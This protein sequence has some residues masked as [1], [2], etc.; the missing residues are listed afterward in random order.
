MS[1]GSFE[2]LSNVF[3]GVSKVSIVYSMDP[4]SIICAS[5]LA[6]FASFKE[7]DFELA[8]FYIAEK[9][10]DGS[11]L[12]LLVGVR[13]QRVVGGLRVK[14]LWD[15]VESKKFLAIKL[16]KELREIWVVSPEQIAM[17]IAA[18]MASYPG[19]SYSDAILSALRSELSELVSAGI[20]SLSEKSLRVFRYPNAK[21]S[22]CLFRTLEPFIPGVSL[23]RE[24]AKRLVEELGIPDR[25][26]VLE[27]EEKRK[28]VE[29]LRGA[30]RDSVLKPV[31]VEGW[32]AVVRGVENVDLNELCYALLAA[33]DADLHEL[34]LAT[35]FK[36]GYCSAIMG[37]LE[38]SYDYIAQFVEEASRGE[39]KVGRMY[40]RGVK[41]HQV[42]AEEGAP[43]NVLSKMLKAHGLADGVVVFRIGERYCVPL[44]DASP[45]WP[46][47]K[48]EGIEFVRGCACSTVMDKLIRVLV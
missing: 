4:E 36:F 11:T 6:N 48:V 45:S 13:Q 18:T 16:T 27:E 5:M 12:V 8:P 23:S 42:E 28:L 2:S 34:C 17:S 15:L 9:P 43:L 37:L 40:I 14:L 44:S 7:L 25:K 22:E 30:L 26:G 1:L 24:G 41:V 38:R 19:P 32:K 20:V 46:M 21:I 47:E 10:I 3:K 33:I 35:L 29:S 31:D 39:K